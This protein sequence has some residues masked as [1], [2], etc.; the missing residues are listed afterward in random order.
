MCAQTIIDVSRC[1]T[2]RERHHPA[3]RNI[4]SRAVMPAAA[5]ALLLATPAAAQDASANASA[6]I[7]NDIQLQNV[8]PLQFAQIVPSGLGG[9]VTINAAT[10]AVTTIG[11]V[12]AIGSNQ[13]RARFSLNAPV[14]TVM[15]LSGD[16]NVTLT[17]NG[18]TETMTASLIHR[19]GTG[20]VSAM[21]VNLPIGLRAIAAEQDIYTGGTLT[22]PGTQAVGT[23]EGSFNL[24]IAYL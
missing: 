15:V 6:A 9:S 20:L 2:G 1:Q 16:A 18:G 4:L 12:V 5:S 3:L 14:G 19:G 8:Q 23:Y 21:V 24:T 17:R 11:Q 10:G 22:V 7:L 13:T